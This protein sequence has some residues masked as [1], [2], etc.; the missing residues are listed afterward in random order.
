MHSTKTNCQDLQ[1]ENPEAV[2]HLFVHFIVSIC[3]FKMMSS[4]SNRNSR[5]SLDQ[6]APLYPGSSSS[7]M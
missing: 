3:Y 7:I 4:Y 6:I 5:L 2:F 1:N